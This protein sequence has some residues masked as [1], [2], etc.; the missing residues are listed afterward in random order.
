MEQKDWITEH[1]FDTFEKAIDF[2]KK[3]GKKFEIT[4]CH[5]S[6][7]FRIHIEDDKTDQPESSNK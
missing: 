6:G 4:I 7:L 3:L 2:G 1:L 5:L